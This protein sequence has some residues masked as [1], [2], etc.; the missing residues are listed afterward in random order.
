MFPNVPLALSR[1]PEQ[2]TEIRDEIPSSQDAL[3][4]L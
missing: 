1:V 3:E 4:A 2:A